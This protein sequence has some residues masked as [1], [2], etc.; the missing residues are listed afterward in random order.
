[1]NFFEAQDDARRRTKWLVLY[2]ILA[3]IG[4]IIAVYAVVAAAMTYLGVGNPLMPGVFLVTAFAT[5]GVMGTGSL[6]KSMQLNGGGSVVARDM[7]ARQVDSHTTDT[8]E[9]RLVNVV[10][11]MAD[12]ISASRAFQV[13]TEIMNTAK[14]M[15]QRVLTIGQ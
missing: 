13:N 2:F 9:R 12:M 10:E 5:G 6:F 1:M 11:E 14:Q 8:D 3:V 7:G 15:V 4:V